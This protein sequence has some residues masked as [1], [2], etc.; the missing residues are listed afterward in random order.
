[1]KQ[2]KRTLNERRCITDTPMHTLK[3]AGAPR[4]R[5]EEKGGRWT[6]AEPETN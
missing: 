3:L 5:D 4:E 2:M 1:M 6:D